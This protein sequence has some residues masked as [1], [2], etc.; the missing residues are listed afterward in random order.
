[1]VNFTR[2]M[3][4]S[5]YF[6]PSTLGEIP[7]FEVSCMAFGYDIFGKHRLEKHRQWDPCAA[8]E[9]C[10]LLQTRC[11]KT[12]GDSLN[13][14]LV[15][16]ILFDQSG[17]FSFP[18]ISCTNWLVG[19]NY[20][21]VSTPRIDDGQMIFH[22]F[23]KGDTT[24]QLHLYALVLCFGLYICEKSARSLHWFA[25]HRLPPSS[26]TH[27]CE[28]QEVQQAMTASTMQYRDVP[29]TAKLYGGFNKW[30]Y[31]NSWMVYNGT[32]H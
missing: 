12:K 31:P 5:C 10:Q 6:K 17:C 9:L 15:I 29:D 19:F 26:D 23:F 1:M 25:G 11:G 21:G 27:T 8:Q 24:K 28:K 2:V 32:T 18:H 20:L 30:G 7:S 14:W 22:S 4:I 16:L 3:V 13:T